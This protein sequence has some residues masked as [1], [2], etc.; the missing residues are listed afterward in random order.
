MQGCRRGGGRCRTGR[1]FPGAPGLRKEARPA[2]LTIA[3]S[4]PCPPRSRQRAASFILPLLSVSPFWDSDLSDPP[5]H[6]LRGPSTASRGTILIKTQARPR[7]T[8]REKTIWFEFAFCVTRGDKP[9][10]QMTQAGT[11]GL[12]MFRIRPQVLSISAVCLGWEGGISS[13]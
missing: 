5:L 4:R 3:A 8:F 2:A 12:G 9:G 7:G 6:G 11:G 13:G 1:P 10:K